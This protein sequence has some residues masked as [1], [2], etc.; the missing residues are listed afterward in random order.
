MVLAKRQNAYGY[1]KVIQSSEAAEK[2]SKIICFKANAIHR[3]SIFVLNIFRLT[4]NSGTAEQDSKYSK[5]DPVQTI[6]IMGEY[7]YNSTYSLPQH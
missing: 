5:V 7:R 4:Y 6:V 3:K 1:R 2:S